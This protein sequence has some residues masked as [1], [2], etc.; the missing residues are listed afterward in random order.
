LLSVSAGSDDERRGE[1]VDELLDGEELRPLPF[2]AEALIPL[3]CCMGLERFESTPSVNWLWRD[4]APR[5][6][7][8]GEGESRRDGMGIGRRGNA[9][10]AAE[11][12]IFAKGIGPANALVIAPRLTIAPARAESIRWRWRGRENKKHPSCSARLASSRSS[13]KDEEKKK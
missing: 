3:P 5:D 10:A 12:S 1:G 7:K 9:A 13:L 11:T 6:E 4:K 2:R 8:E